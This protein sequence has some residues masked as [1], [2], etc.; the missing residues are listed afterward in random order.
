[1]KT[2]IYLYKCALKI[3]CFVENG[4]CMPAV[5]ALHT[6]AEFFSNLQGILDVLPVPLK[7]RDLDAIDTPIEYLLLSGKI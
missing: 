7:A 4:R 1:M 6:K 3:I 5:F 2:N